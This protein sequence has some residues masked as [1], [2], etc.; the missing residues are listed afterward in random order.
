MLEA[1]DHDDRRA[2]REETR[3]LHLRRRPA[4]PALRRVG[5]LHRSRLPA[6]HLGQARPPPSARLRS[7]HDG[8]ATW[9]PAAP[10]H[11]RR[12]GRA[13][14]G[15]EGPRAEQQGRTAH[16]PRRRAQG[17]A[18]APAHARNRH[19][20]VR[21]RLRLGARRRRRGEDRRGSRRAARRLGRRR[22]DQRANAPKKRWATCSSRSRT[23]R[24]K[25]GIEPESALRKANDKFTRRFSAMES[26]LRASG[27]PLSDCSLQEMEDE[28]S[29]RQAGGTRGGRRPGR[30]VRL[31]PVNVVT[32]T[33]PAVGAQR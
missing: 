23:S 14:G 33:D 31:R 22:R 20:G 27:R 1:L 2:L 30:S 5:R 6:R 12:S 18:G 15:L 32:S 4:G 8:E 28:W 11:A 16:R 13:M 29:R 10:D 24:R 25:L 9:R 21:R 19:P 17:P 7:R 26:R 3:R